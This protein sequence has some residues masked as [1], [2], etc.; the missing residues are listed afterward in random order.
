MMS[1]ILQKVQDNRPLKYPTVR[2]VT[3]LD[4]RKMFSDP[5]CCKGKM[6][7][8][9]QRFLQDKQVSGGVCHALLKR[10]ADMNPKARLRGRQSSGM[11]R[12]I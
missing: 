8:L 7:N 4:P 11:F 3:C 12:F 1:T 5:D 2:Q 6:R 10:L 9:V